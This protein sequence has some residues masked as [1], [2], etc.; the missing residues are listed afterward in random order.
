MHINLSWDL[1]IIVFFLVIIAYSFVIGKNQ[2]MKVILSTYVAILAA[3]GAGNL[4]Q[5][6]FLGSDPVI[7]LFAVQANN[8]AFVVMKISIFVL[9]TV[10]LTVR[11]AFQIDLMQDKSRFFSVFLTGAY[12]VL[13]A[14]LIISTILVYVSG[15]SLFHAFA[16]SPE[17]PIIAIAADSTLV[18][19]MVENYSVWFSF[20]A[21]VFMIASLFGGDE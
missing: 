10:L 1:F 2:T 15:V 5:K 16:P 17:N 11:G 9:L 14:G 7:N 8:S 18:R 6:Y 21:V 13:S 3:D 20:P 4:V 12:G 19:T